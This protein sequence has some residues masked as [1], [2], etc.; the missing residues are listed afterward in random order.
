MVL[1]HLT[2]CVSVNYSYQVKGCV[3]KFRGSWH[4]Y[5]FQRPIRRHLLSISRNRKKCYGLSASGS[6]IHVVEL[7]HYSF[8]IVGWPGIGIETMVSVWFWFL[9]FLLIFLLKKRDFLSSLDSRLWNSKEKKFYFFL[10]R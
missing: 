10:L 3:T 2:V 8:Q 9:M 6:W 1:G 4:S 7:R 5:E